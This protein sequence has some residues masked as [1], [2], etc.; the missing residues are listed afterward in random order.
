[1]ESA[2]ISLFLPPSQQV[3]QAVSSASTTGVLKPVSSRP[4]GR[5]RLHIP[6]SSLPPG[7]VLASREGIIIII[8]NTLL[9][10]PLQQ[11]ILCASGKL[12]G[13]WLTNCLR[14]DPHSTHCKKILK[15]S[16]LL[17]IKGVVYILVFVL[18]VMCSMVK[19]MVFC[20]TRISPT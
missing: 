6:Q 9:P 8:M 11:Y 13:S 5:P 1:M 3:K 14:C 10:P 15:L 7:K 20:E 18:M 19:C 4:V 17:A 12:W 16:C 2:L